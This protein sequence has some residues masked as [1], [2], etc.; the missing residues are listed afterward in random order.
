MTQHQWFSAAFLFI[1]IVLIIELGVVI[2]S[3]LPTILWAMILAQLA[4]PIYVKVLHRLGGRETPAALLLTLGVMAL[5]VTPALYV[6]IVGLEEGLAAYKDF[7]AWIQ[8]GGL[9]TVGESLSALPIIGRLS[10]PL[11]GQLIVSNGTVELSLLEGS[12]WVS[13]Y[14]ATQ[15]GDLAK[16]GLL[17]ATHFLILFLTLFFLFRD[18]RRLYSRLAH[19]LPLEPS[20]KIRIFRHLGR[21]TT[22]IVR[23]TLLSA[24]GQGVI[25][26]LVL[27]LLG[28][29]FPVFLG[30]V[31]VL[32]ALLPVGG[33]ALVWGPMVIWL[34]ATGAILKACLLTAM[35][36]TLIALMDNVLYYWITGSTARL[37]MLFLFFV[38]IGGLAHFGF[39]GL[40]LGPML[41]A[42]VIA[43]F[44]IFEDQYL[45]R[46]PAL[47]V[48]RTSVR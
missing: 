47:L 45:E 16:N 39:I 9:Q 13:S 40:F 27:A 31:S 44:E 18:G 42:A 36:M 11:M 8:A 5:A 33:A 48:K 41:L 12:K 10:Q 22:A 20:H 32:L 7:A 17:F 14:L 1:F 6:V 24:V 2:G 37:P 21:T 26:G 34:L 35:G 4:N 43:A 3:F 46:D 25:V 23:G 19:A 38:T 30:S 28:L 15:A 29:P